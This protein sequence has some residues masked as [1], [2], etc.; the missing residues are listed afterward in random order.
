MLENSYAIYSDN[1]YLREMAER[2]LKNT[3][4]QTIFS[5][6]FTGPVIELYEENNNPEKKSHIF[7]KSNANVRLTDLIN[8]NCKIISLSDEISPQQAIL[9]DLVHLNI[10]G[11]KNY[12]LCAYALS[13][14]IRIIE[15]NQE[16]KKT[17]NLM[18]L[19]NAGDKKNEQIHK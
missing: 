6:E 16:I 5:V 10:T 8:F 7:I 12:T 19:P 3:L 9:K 15:S 1:P 17:L 13:L 11:I 2:I 18:L 4:K 14:A